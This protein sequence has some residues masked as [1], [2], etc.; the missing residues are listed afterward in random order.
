M[1][2]AVIHRVDNGDTSG[3]SGVE[4]GDTV[5]DAVFLLRDQMTHLQESGIG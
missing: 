2:R 1:Q 3:T 5:P 4:F